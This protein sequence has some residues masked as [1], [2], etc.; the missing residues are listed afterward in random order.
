MSHVTNLAISLLAALA[1]AI[2]T[3]GAQ[4]AVLQAG[5]VT[6]GHVPTYVAG[7]WAPVIV[8]GG[9]AAGGAVGV[10]LSEL[11]LTVRGTGT[12]PY[13]AGGSG[14]AG[15]NL[16]DYDGPTTGAFHYLCL[17]PNVGGNG[18][19][20]Y[21][22]GGGATP[23]ALNLKVNGTTY[24][25]PFAI[26]GIVGPATSVVND[27]ACWNNLTGSLLKDCG[28]LP[29]IA[30]GSTN[31]L[32]Y[33]T[34]ANA[35]G[36][37]TGS[38]SSVL[39]TNGSSVAA[40]ATTL[41]TGLT[42]PTATITNPTLTGGTIGGSV[43][44]TASNASLTSPTI[45]NASE[46]TPTIT[47]PTVTGGT[48]SSALWSPGTGTITA[49]STTDL[50]S[51]TADNVTVTGN[52]T[53][54]ALGTVTSGVKKW[55]TF[56]GTPVLTYNAS[57]LIVPGS[58]N[59]S[60][61]AGDTAVAQS[62]GSGN[63][64]VISY[65]RLNGTAFTSPMPVSFRN[66]KIQVTSNTAITVSADQ[67]TLANGSG[68]YL[69]ITNF[70]QSIATGTSGA[71]GLDTGSIGASSWYNVYGGAKVDGTP[72]AYLSLSAT[73]PT[74]PSGY[75]Y[76]GRIGAV[77]TNGSNNLLATLQSGRRTQYVV[78]GSNVANLPLMASGSAG[79]VT[80][81]T[82]V[83]VATGTF[84]PPTTS[85]IK[86][87]MEAPNGT[88]VAPNNSYGPNNSTTN[89]PPLVANVTG[90]VNLQGEIILESTNIYWASISAG[91]GLFCLGWEDNL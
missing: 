20:S 12:A 86:V 6:A 18:L 60:V 90:Y 37:L 71:G 16:C 74:L 48:I 38:A 8:D 39:T 67:L 81:P 61:T 80:V 43:V 21:G 1:L 11:G 56:T 84:V 29:T 30:T 59:I 89:P 7:T 49:A 28:T 25:F 19:I 33:Y 2:P 83:A 47:N 68:N 5:A 26:S 76:Y 4:Q 45:T 78:G 27:I 65:T 14:P 15:E 85:A 53:I 44:I 10:G 72:T 46:T 82:W 58:A 77:R 87:I 88:M 23:G 22:S 51:I 35:L 62:L 17:S 54:N 34:G 13:N 32:A 57:S 63:W 24:A 75:T 73:A 50:S 9:S 70:S 66:L 3:A 64:R 69:S 79:S 40:W 31:Q 91:S 42:L 36:G 41:P 52:S 55:L